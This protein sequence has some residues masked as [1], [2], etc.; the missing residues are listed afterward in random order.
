VIEPTFI[1]PRFIKNFFISSI[2]TCFNNW[3]FVDV[4]FRMVLFE[5]KTD[6]FGAV[7]DF[8]TL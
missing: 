8:P 2:G 5:T 7:F 4:L 6:T 1:R 3:D